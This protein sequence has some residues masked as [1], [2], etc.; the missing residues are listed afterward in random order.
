[1]DPQVVLQER[2]N[3]KNASLNSLFKKLKSVFF[4]KHIPCLFIDAIFL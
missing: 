2:G 3:D 4:T 1:M